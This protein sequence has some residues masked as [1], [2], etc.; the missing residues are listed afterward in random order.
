MPPNV[1]SEGIGDKGV[2]RQVPDAHGREVPS[3]KELS[4]VRAL[5]VC[6]TLV[7][8]WPM[9]SKWGARAG[10]GVFEGVWSEESVVGRRGQRERSGGY[11]YFPCA[12][13]TW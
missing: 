9:K 3:H 11:P 1:H 5:V 8:S 12:V 13:V 4:Q 6:S 7:L 10:P 2:I